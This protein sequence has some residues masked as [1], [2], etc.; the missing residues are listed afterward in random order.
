VIPDL[1]AKETFPFPY[2]TYI[3]TG[4]V[5]GTFYGRHQFVDPGWVGT[6]EIE[7]TGLT[8]D[9]TSGDERAPA[10]NS[11]QFCF[12]ELANDRRNPTLKRRQ[13]TISTLR[14]C[15]IHPAHA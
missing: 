10:G 3:H 15:K 7:I 9:I 13:H 4:F 5:Q 1:K 12:W 2:A 14:C 6:K 8:I 11:K